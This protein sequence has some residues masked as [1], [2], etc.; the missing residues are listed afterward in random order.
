MIINLQPIQA[1]IAAGEADADTM[2]LMA[3]VKRLMHQASDWESIARR[4]KSEQIRLAAEV[5]RLQDFRLTL[6]DALHNLIQQ[7]RSDNVM[8]IEAALH[9]A[10]RVLEDA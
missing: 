10:E 7:F 2:A 6:K 4:C 5:K 1:R 9:A 8:S 3:E